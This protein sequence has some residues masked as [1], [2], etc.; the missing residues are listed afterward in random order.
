MKKQQA[1]RT[2]EK[3]SLPAEYLSVYYLPPTGP[4][5]IP[6]RGGERA[7]NKA[8]EA[9]EKESTRATQQGV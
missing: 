2:D 7:P 9:A 6:V 3:C 4:R 8:D 1:K 5:Q